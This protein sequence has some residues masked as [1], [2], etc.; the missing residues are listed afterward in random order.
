MVDIQHRVISEGDIH[1]IVN[2]VWVDET[3]RLAQIVTAEDVFKVG[4]Q[5]S[6]QS[7]YILINTT[8]TWNIILNET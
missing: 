7:L 3:A 8:P 2:W 6:N 1:Q 5:Q 4:Y